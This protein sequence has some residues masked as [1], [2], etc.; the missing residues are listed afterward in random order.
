MMTFG[1]K[2]KEMYAFCST[3]PG[4]LLLR[5]TKDSALIVNSDNYF[6]S[7]LVG[8][9]K[10]HANFIHIMNGRYGIIRVDTPTT[11]ADILINAM[12]DMLDNQTESIMNIDIEDLYPV[13]VN[14]VGND[15]LA[16]NPIT[17][18]VAKQGRQSYKA[19]LED[20]KFLF[21]KWKH[22]NKCMV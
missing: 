21:Q 2:E 11:H 17:K 9:L 10:F 18:E 5:G 1:E 4:T 6:G 12:L 20:A 8:V 16:S 15:W 19:A 13:V 22:V 14:L 7:G 3:E